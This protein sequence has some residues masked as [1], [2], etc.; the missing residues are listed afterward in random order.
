MRKT[1]EATL[2]IEFVP[3]RSHRSHL[4]MSNENSPLVRSIS[5]ARSPLKQM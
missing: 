2:T 1:D 3:S 4:L 5:P